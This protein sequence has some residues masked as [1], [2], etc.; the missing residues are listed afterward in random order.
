MTAPVLIQSNT[1]PEVYLLIR[2]QKRHIPDMET[3][4]AFEFNGSDIIK[5]YRHFNQ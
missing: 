3:F 4:N 1:Q 5:N 2:N